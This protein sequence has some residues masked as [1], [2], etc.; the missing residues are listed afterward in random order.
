VPIRVAAR[1]SHAQ[2]CDTSPPIHVHA[3]RPRQLAPPAVAHFEPSAPA[4]A[5]ESAQ[6]TVSDPRTASDRKGTWRRI[7]RKKHLA[8]QALE[9]AQ[10]TV[11]ACPD[12]YVLCPRKAAA[13]SGDSSNMPWLS[14]AMSTIA[15]LPSAN[16]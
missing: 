6:A 8:A 2:T 4:M 16:A 14:N 11:A 10:A 7:Q 15:S 9:S 5:L 3:L 1:R 12:S 13:T